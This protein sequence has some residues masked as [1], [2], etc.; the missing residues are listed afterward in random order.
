VTGA[1][2]LDN[3]RGWRGPRFPER[4]GRSMPHRPPRRRGF[5]LIELLVVI[6]IIAILAAI[7]FPV[8]AQARD[9]ARQSTC[10]SNEKQLGTGLMMY[11]Q[12][13]DEN[14]PSWPYGKNDIRQSPIFKSGWGYSVWVPALMPYVKNEGVFA[15]PNG[16]RTGTSFPNQAIA[17]PKG[18][19]MV[20]NLAYNEYI[21]NRDFGFSS[22]ASLSGARN[23]VADITVIGESPYNGIYQDWSDNFKIPDRPNRFG[24]WRFYC[25]NKA[26]PCE[27]RHK[28]H[29]IN[30]VFADGHAKFVPG[31]SIQGGAGDKQEWPIVNP[32]K[33]PWK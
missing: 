21:L 10:L 11:A 32:N 28:E 7:L 12:D 25:A 14:L 20:V 27:G 26:Q 22:I 17:G 18:Q 19:E 24:L 30:A 5:T 2:E 33:E 29:G 1:G 13:Y 31:A 23:S 16:P 8:F 9:S 3:K 4:R 6:A 15:C